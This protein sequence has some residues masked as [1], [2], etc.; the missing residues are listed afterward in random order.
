MM[1]SAL[2]TLWRAILWNHTPDSKSDMEFHET[3]NIM[4]PGNNSSIP[5]IRGMWDG[6]PLIMNWPS[7]IW[8]CMFPG[9]LTMI[10][11]TQARSRI[12]HI[13]RRTPAKAGPSDEW[14][15]W[16]RE[17][18]A[19]LMCKCIF[20]VTITFLGR[21][22]W[23]WCLCQTSQSQTWYWWEVHRSLYLVWLKSSC[24]NRYL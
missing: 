1:Q 8:I 24:R 2:K 22:L 18:A 9:Y 4:W 17:C 16:S 14:L 15:I 13:A 3:C 12:T 5:N 10:A 6:R 19:L 11:R 7:P 20:P 21:L 23:W